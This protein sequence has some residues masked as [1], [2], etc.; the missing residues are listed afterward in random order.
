MSPYF[1]LGLKFPGRESSDFHGKKLK[2]MKTH[3]GFFQTKLFSIVLC[4]VMAMTA[5][6]FAA[7]AAIDPRMVDI[8]ISSNTQNVLLYARLVDCFKPEMEA[9]ILAGVPAIFT[10]QL[11]VYQERS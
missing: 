6:P 3:N 1:R 7:K 4:L 11:E 9:A 10:L 8:L 5:M 2:Y